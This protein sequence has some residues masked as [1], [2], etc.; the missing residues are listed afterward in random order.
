MDFRCIFSATALTLTTFA[1][2][3][4]LSAEAP[5]EIRIHWTHSASTA[6]SLARQFNLPILAYVS[7]ENCGYCRKME[8]E[9]W[10]NPDI[11]SMV[12]AGFVP[13][14]LTAERDPELVASL[15]IRAL[16]TTLVYSPD[17]RPIQRVTGYQRPTQFAAILRASIAGQATRPQTASSA[18]A[19]Q[20]GIRWQ[21][22]V[23]T[24][25]TLAQQ[26]KAPILV[27]VS[28]N[29]CGHCRKMESDVWSNADIVAMVET[30]F[31]PLELSAERDSKL[32]ASLN[33]Q[34]FPT[35]ILYSADAEYLTSAAGYL[36][37]DQL[38]D[39]L[40]GGQQSHLASQQVVQSQ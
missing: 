39:L 36:R 33:V 11:V 13:L 1:G 30:G 6:A 4:T 24:A 22:S 37:P 26:S 16:P 38:A 14:E 10:S 31:I 7:S 19:S 17:V 9:V 15:Q 32:V 23:E 40:R 34:G 20:R 25:T 3:S 21:H 35:T 12:E 18:V 8:R 27:Y 29:D 28:S 2:A 5:A